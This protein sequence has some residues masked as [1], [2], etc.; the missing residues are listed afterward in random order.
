MNWKDSSIK[1]CTTSI[2]L[3][4]AP[5]TN[6]PL[7]RYLPDTNQEAYQCKETAKKQHK[8]TILPVGKKRPK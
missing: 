5:Q 3:V 1:V 2:T 8:Q 7:I 4:S 6:A